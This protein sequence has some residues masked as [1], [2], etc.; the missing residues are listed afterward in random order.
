M[1]RKVFGITVYEDYSNY[2]DDIVAIA[3][4]MESLLKKKRKT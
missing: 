1:E 2:F 4:I 3:E